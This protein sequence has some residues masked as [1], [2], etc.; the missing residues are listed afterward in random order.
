MGLRTPYEIAPLILNAT[1]GVAKLWAIPFPS[2]VRLTRLNLI[3]TSG[4][5]VAFTVDLFSAGP[6]QGLTDAPQALDEIYRVSPTIN[7]DVAGHMVHFFP[8]VDVYFFNQDAVNRPAGASESGQNRVIY[9][10]L[11]PQGAG[12]Q[13]YTLVMAAEMFG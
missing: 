3:Q 13:S 2:R 7:S 4:A 8:D 9:M 10:R 5:L 11:T 1:G 6:S 12:A